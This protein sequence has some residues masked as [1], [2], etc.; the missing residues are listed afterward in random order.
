[1]FRPSLNIEHPA[2]SGGH[3]GNLQQHLATH[4]VPSGP[5][6]QP[7]PS[8]HCIP[9]H[10]LAC[11]GVLNVSQCPQCS[12]TNIPPTSA[13]G[14]PCRQPSSNACTLW[15]LN[16][17]FLTPRSNLWVD[18]HISSP[19]VL[20]LTVRADMDNVSVTTDCSCCGQN[21]LHGGGEID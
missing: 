20:S 18:P 6:Y 21:L 3:I 11:W 15:T 13:S 2:V 4:P 9:S 12:H 7:S 14:L 19:F 5:D 8:K 17:K 16:G 1:M 10:L